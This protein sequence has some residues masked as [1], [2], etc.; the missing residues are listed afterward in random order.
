MKTIYENNVL[1]IKG[2]EFI[3]RYSNLEIVQ[4]NKEE[5]QIDNPDIF[6]DWMYMYYDV[7]LL[8]INDDGSEILIHKTKT[9]DEPTLPHLYNAAKE[10]MQ[11]KKGNT[12]DESKNCNVISKSYHDAIIEEDSY[13]IRK[14]FN[15]ETMASWYW[16]SITIFL[17]LDYAGFSIVMPFLYECEIKDMC[18][19]IKKFISDGWCKI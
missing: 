6:S 4:Y 10:L 1:E 12:Y 5:K 3:I 15:K 19:N 18:D 9:C 2:S 8:K 13:E 11:C 17:K 16:L 7:E 14:Y